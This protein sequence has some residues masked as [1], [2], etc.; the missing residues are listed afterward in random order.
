[1]PYGCC[2]VVTYPSFRVVVAVSRALLWAP[3][4]T[5]RPPANAPMRARARRPV[6]H[7]R[8]LILSPL[9]GGR[10]PGRADSRR[11]RQGAPQS[12]ST[13]AT[14]GAPRGGCQHPHE[15]VPHHETPVFI[16]VLAAL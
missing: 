7:P 13:G 5:D 2:G 15:L 4:A 16:G 10:W 3:P 14:L 12:P 6:T 9:L 8:R 11:V 1:M